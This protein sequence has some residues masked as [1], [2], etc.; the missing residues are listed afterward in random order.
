M[1]QV[2]ATAPAA[3]SFLWRATLDAAG[4][5]A[6]HQAAVAKA[7]PGMVRLDSLSHFEGHC[8]DR[9]Q[10]LGCFLD[11]GEMIAYGVLAFD[12]PTVDHLAEMLG[13]PRGLFCALDGAAALPQW[14]G[15]NLH[16]ACIAQRVAHAA[17]RGLTRAGATVAPENIRSLRALVRARLVIR[18][19]ARMYGGLS[20]L[21]LERDAL[22]GELAWEHRSS[23]P[24]T[25]H[26]AH[27][28]ALAAGLAGYQ[29]RQDEEGRWLIDYGD[30]PGR[31]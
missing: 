12:S 14:R 22:A 4:A 26:D 30:Q 16:N 5:H 20:R 13:S 25:D 18:G 8:G 3:V 19:Y 2:L 6:V 23:V 1:S 21:V 31:P 28:D 7:P 24:A 27:Q 9:G 17:T 10:I 11:T 15:F 29:C